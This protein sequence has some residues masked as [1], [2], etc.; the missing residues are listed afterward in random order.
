MTP[1]SSGGRAWLRLTLAVSVATAAMAQSPSSPSPT[2]DERIDQLSHEV[3]DLKALVHQLQDQLAKVTGA[4]AAPAPAATPPAS[5]PAAVPDFWHGV[6]FNAL[7]DGYYEY[8]TNAPLGR[9]NLLR[10]Y[11]VSSNSFSLN[12]ADVVIERVPDL[13]HDQRIGMRL[14]LQYGQATSTTQGNP[15][16]EPRPDI[17]RNVFQAYGTYVFP[18]AAG[19]TVDFGKWSSSLGLEGNYT[20]DQLNYSRSF[21]FDYLPFYHM[22]VRSKLAL[23]DQWAVNA[24]ITNGTNQTEAYNSY[25]D[26]L[27]GLVYTPSQAFNWTFNVYQGQDH[28][29]VIYVQNPTPL[30]QA[31]LPEVQGTY[32][33][34]ITDPG[35]GRVHIVDSYVT[36]L[37]T[38]ALTLAIEGDYV[39]QRLYQYSRPQRV[40]GGALYAGYQVTPQFSV[41]ARAEYLEDAGGLYTGLTQYLTEQTLTVDYRPADGLLVRGEFRRDHSN[42]PYFLTHSLGSLETSQPTIGFGLVWWFGQ[43]QGAW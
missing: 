29:D 14:D 26:Q 41:A 9:V 7:L 15:V 24:W 27:L 35:N 16:N 18:V 1:R 10:A 43:K 36:W 19:L 40:D 28:P 17:Y 25:K 12:Q 34:P 31:T 6:T 4:A 22:G 11:D 23:N 30:Q 39:Q 37:P 32:L 20:K 3:Q 13:A 8:N 38:A 33:Q 42:Q 2:A 5:T 21:W